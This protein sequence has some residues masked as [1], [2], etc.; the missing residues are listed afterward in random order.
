MS[1]SSSGTTAPDQAEV[2]EERERRKAE[3]GGGQGVPGYG[4]HTLFTE[5]PRRG[6]LG[7]SGIGSLGLQLSHCSIYYK[8]GKEAF[9]G[10]LREEA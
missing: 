6:L 9:L 8:S 3:T 10:P 1:R 5:L 4:G 7:N 2:R